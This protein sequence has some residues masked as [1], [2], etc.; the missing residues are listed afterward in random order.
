M[1]TLE[2]VLPAYLAAW[3]EVDE[4]KR[5]ALLEICWAEQGVYSDP[6]A[7]APG[8]EALLR[9]IGRVLRHFAGHRCLLTSGV[10]EHHN[11]IRFT[12]A[13][14]SPDGKKVAEG[15]DFGELG[16]DGR[17]VRITGFFGPIPPPSPSWPADSMLPGLIR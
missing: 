5:R 17:L 2:K 11:C 6:G 7:E 15:I 14:V 10:E 13:M 4:E 3:S 16:T 1:T 8:R 12:W 9:H